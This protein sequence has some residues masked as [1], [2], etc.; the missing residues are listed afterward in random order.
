MPP[1]RRDRDTVE[2]RAGYRCEYCRIVGWELQVDHI[3][4]R[5]PRRRSA[6]DFLPESLDDQDNLA[7]A[8]AHCNRFKA[9]F[10]TGRDPVSGR[11][12]RLFNPRRDTWEEHFDWSVD[13]L[14]LLPLSA[15]GGATITR[16]RMNAPIL[17]RQRRLLRQAMP[18]GGLPWP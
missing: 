6:A 1:A 16:L 14:R 2:R 18:S 10:T 7:A 15:I 11:E 4:P 9:D 8:C 12:V 13:Y 5:S 17:V 3:V